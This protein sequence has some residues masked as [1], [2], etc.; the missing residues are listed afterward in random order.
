M[1]NSVLRACCLLACMAC[2]PAYA[3]YPNSGVAFGAAVLGDQS[4]LVLPFPALPQASSLLGTLG[5]PAPVQTALYLAPGATKAVTISLSCATVVYSWNHDVV[6]EWQEFYASG[7][8]S[9]NQY[10]AI[11]MATISMGNFK[12]VS[13]PLSYLLL[14]PTQRAQLPAGVVNTVGLI[15]LQL[16]AYTA[17]LPLN[18]VT[19][20]VMV[21]A[22]VTRSAAL[23][24]YWNIE[25]CHA[26]PVAYNVPW[27]QQGM[28]VIVGG[29]VP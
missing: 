29:S 17:S 11:R 26:A 20:N 4:T 25:T 6:S 22:D 19:E 7:K 27:V 9:D 12:G 23:S 24:T 14:T 1:K 21:Q 5:V 8:G 13:W 16:Q 15:D 3:G 18:Y 2:G 10:Y 28:F